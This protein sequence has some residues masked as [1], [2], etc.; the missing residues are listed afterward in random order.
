MNKWKIY[1]DIWTY[2]NQGLQNFSQHSGNN[3]SSRP[4]Q[5]FGPSLRANHALLN[6]AA[7]TQTGIGW[8]ESLKG[9]ISREWAKLLTK[10][11]GYQTAKV[12]KQARIQSLWDHTYRL[13]I[14][15]NNEDHKNDNHIIAQYKQQAPIISIVQ[16]YHTFNTCNIPLNPLQQNH[17]DIP[18]YQLLILSYGI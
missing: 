13:W 9:Q 4:T 10:S 11:L 17:F 5:P 14:F 8:H 15:R 2:F 7:E 16:Q 3:D 1:Q 18:K 6:N 12:C